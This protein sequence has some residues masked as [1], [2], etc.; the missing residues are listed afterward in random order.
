MVSDE[1]PICV[2]AHVENF[3]IGGIDQEKA[4]QAADKVL[5]QS[6]RQNLQ[7]HD[8]IRSSPGGEF[9]GLCFGADGGRQRIWR[10]RPAI[11][12]LGAA[13]GE[14]SGTRFA[15]SSW[16][17]LLERPALALLDATFAFSAAYGPRAAPLWGGVRRELTRVAAILPLCRSNA[18]AQWHGLAVA[19]DVL[20]VG[21]GACHRRTSPN[22]LGASG[23]VEAC[24][25]RVP[26][27]VHAQRHALGESSPAD[28]QTGRSQVHPGPPDDIAIRRADQE[29]SK[30]RPESMSPGLWQTIW[31]APVFGPE[32]SSG[33]RPARGYGG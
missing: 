4:Q 6:Q 17:L 24:R 11:D 26:E 25:F 8:I 12:A 32:T 20:Q 19:S 7:T 5:K 1:A 28:I 27:V 33:E 29:F 2:A 10:L 9:V 16:A 30:V 13:R 23:D 15:P 14:V 31:Y 3:W 22:K 18:S 21:Y